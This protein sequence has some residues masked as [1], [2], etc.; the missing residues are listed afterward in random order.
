[1]IAVCAL[2]FQ[3]Q[4]VEAQ[5][6]NWAN[7]NIGAASGSSSP[8]SATA[9]RV[10]ATGD[11]IW[12]T[13]DAFHFVYGQLSGDFDISGRVANFDVANEWSKAGL[14]IRESLNA[15]S[16]NVYALTSPGTGVALQARSATGGTTTR[17]DGPVVAVPVW[18]R[19]VRAGSTYTAYHSLDG[20]NWTRISSQTVSMPS[21][22]YVGVAVTSR[23]TTS[24]TAVVDNI[25][26]TTGA[27]APS[28]PPP[29][30]TWSNRDIGSPARSGSFSQSS[31]TLTVNG[32]GRDIWNTS[33][34]FHFA[35]Q[36]F[37]GDVEL[38]ARVS[39]LTATETWA[40]AGVMIRASLD[41]QS[42]HAMMLAS[43]AG[44][45]SFQRR[46]ATG[47]QSYMDAGPAGVA[48]G[49]VRLVREGDLISAYVSSDGSRWTLVGTDRISMSSSVYVGVAVTS[50][51]SLLMARG[52]FTNF[53]VR[54]PTPGGN[55]PPTVT[56]TA[57]ANG[58][59]FTAPATVTM[60]ASASDSDG[61]VS[62]VD[63]YR[64]SQLVGSD[65]TAP[66]SFS[67]SNQAAGSFA[68]TAVAT[69]NEG[70]TTSS[71]AVNITVNGSTNR[72]PTVS[73][74]APAGGAT[75]TAPAT[76]SL[77]A[78]ASDPDGTIARV[79]F[80]R[81]STLI[82]SD[83]SSPYTATWSSAAAGTYSLTAVARDNAGATTTSTAVTVTVNPANNAAPTVSLTS[84][85][86]GATFTAPAN[87]TLQASA[88]D[89]DGRITRVEFYRGSTL[90]ASDTTSPYSATWSSAPAGTY[91]LT[92]RAFDE[93]GAST[94]SAAVSITVRTASN[95]LPNVSIT[96]PAGGASYTAP[97]SVTINA[98]ASD[99][100]GTIARVD[101]YAGSQLIAS[102]TSSPYTASWTNVAAGTYSLTAVA[103]DNA[104][105]T[106]TSAAVSV[107]VSAAGT[108]AT[109]VQF[110]PSS[111]HS[112][113]VTS[114]VVAIYRG[115]DPVTAS[116]VATRDLGKPTPTSG[117][118][119][120][121]VSTLVNSLPAGSYKAVV[122][123]TN[124]AGVTAST[125]SGTFT[126]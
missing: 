83:T 107:T 82:S 41:G 124:A 40:K 1:M 53:T 102:D 78:T 77:A 114:Y 34:Q 59:T 119:T 101:F 24:A 55:T 93:D 15:N 86:G 29:A 88:A 45:W 16:R 112:T 64:G 72:A 105:A 18:L 94:T 97:A 108:P 85:G 65:T 10:T 109:R 91:S 110:T 26:L 61:S 13:A 126:K 11:N 111:D 37:S 17:V 46:I 57:P 52:T 74:T 113:N 66:Y 25:A 106:R 98:T 42:R 3:P 6:L 69:D 67:W 73:L 30:S 9:V 121:D 36:Q 122:R 123:A 23:A 27:S 125:P 12:G 120:V 92:A 44:G 99:P 117:S 48:P 56:V 22:V 63:F 96:S 100:D 89:S 50:H 95:Q 116:P 7:R 5:S 70:A 103:R 90:I 39:S 84:P 21:T 80:Y 51:N 28:T 75:Y 115:S 38:I 81:G 31:G 49:W 4:Y 87:I 54:K 19:L 76:I 104:G 2:L 118:I 71:S 14:M 47:G 32:A 58:S 79:D 8:E 33:D 68:L 43:K 35:Y 60:T 20:D 62:R